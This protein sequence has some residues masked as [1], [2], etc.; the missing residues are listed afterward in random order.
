MSDLFK[1]INK[2]CLPAQIYLGISTISILG[3][4]FQNIGQQNKYCIGK[5]NAELPCNNMSVFLFKIVYVIIVTWILQ[6]LCARGYKSISW[7]LV[8]LPYILMFT[9]IALMVLFFKL[10]PNQ[11]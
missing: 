6:K 2:I 3:M 1:T 11:L 9:L 4:L 5:F 7:L 10:N 8:L